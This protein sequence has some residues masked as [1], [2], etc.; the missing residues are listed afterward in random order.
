MRRHQPRK[1]LITLFAMAS[2]RPGLPWPALTG[3][4]LIAALAA[5]MIE[6]RVATR[7]LR[8]RPELLEHGR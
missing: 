8:I 5:F 2:R 1:R 7:A 3:R 6:V 4:L